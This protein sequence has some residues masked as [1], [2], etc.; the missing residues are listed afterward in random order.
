[1]SLGFTCTV[2]SRI[3]VDSVM[4]FYAKETEGYA[5]CV[6]KYSIVYKRHREKVRDK[7]KKKE[8][9]RDRKTETE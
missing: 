1:M 5:Q 3:H 2:G 8:R 4:E 6:Y 9:A 7:A